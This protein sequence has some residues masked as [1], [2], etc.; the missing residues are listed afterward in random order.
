MANT[1][2][3]VIDAKLKRTTVNVEFAGDEYDEFMR[4]RESTGE[5][6]PSLCRSSV[7]AY[8]RLQEQAIASLSDGSAAKLGEIEQRMA[9]EQRDMRNEI[10]L[11]RREL[12]A[13]AALLDSFLKVFLTHIPVP[14]VAA[15]AELIASARE[16]H[17]KVL[18]TTAERFDGEQAKVLGELE[19]RVVKAQFGGEAED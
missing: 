11:V 9:A 1:K 13:T 10:K 18:R 4:L 7:F 17:E 6:G 12:N 8:H 5:S 19:D 16:R 3:G 14:P 2:K 15:R